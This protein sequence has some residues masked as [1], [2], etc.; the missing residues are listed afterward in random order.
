MR[1]A[2]QHRWSSLAK[3]LVAGCTTGAVVAL[4]LVPWSGA[5]VRR[6]LRQCG[7]SL[8]ERTTDIIIQVRTTI[9]EILGRRPA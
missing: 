5:E 6:Y 3:G 1:D 8:Q 4:L 9:E 7:Q 2:G